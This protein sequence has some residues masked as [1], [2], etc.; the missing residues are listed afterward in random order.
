MSHSFDQQTQ[1]AENSQRTWQQGSSGSQNSFDWQRSAEQYDSRSGDMGCSNA[2]SQTLGSNC[3][4]RPT[5]NEGPVSESPGSGA[6]PGERQDLCQQTHNSAEN[7][8]SNPGNGGGNKSSRKRGRRGNKDNPPKE[9]PAP[10]PLKKYK[11]SESDGFWS[12]RNDFWKTRGDLRV[13]FKTPP[14]AAAGRPPVHWSIEDEAEDADERPSHL[15]IPVE[16][17]NNLS[18]S[19]QDKTERSDA[20]SKEGEVSPAEENKEETDD[21]DLA[22]YTTLKN[23]IFLQIEENDQDMLSNLF[24]TSSDLIAQAACRILDDA[25]LTLLTLLLRYQALGMEDIQV[26]VQ[27]AFQSMTRG[28]T[29]EILQ[30]AEMLKGLVLRFFRC[31]GDKNWNALERALGS[32]RLEFIPLKKFLMTEIAKLEGELQKAEEISEKVVQILLLVGANNNYLVQ[33]SCSILF[34]NQEKNSHNVQSVS[35]LE[36]EGYLRGLLHSSF[37]KAFQRSELPL[38]TALNLI[39]NFFLSPSHKSGQQPGGLEADER[40]Q[41]DT[42]Y[43]SLIQGVIDQYPKKKPHEGCRSFI[44]VLLAC[45][46]S[47]NVLMLMMD[48]LTESKLAEH[49]AN[50]KMIEMKDVQRKRSQDFKRKLIDITDKEFLKSGPKD[51]PKEL[52]IRITTKFYIIKNLPTFNQLLDNKESTKKSAST[53]PGYLSTIA[54]LSNYEPLV[55]YLT[56]KLIAGRVPLFTVGVFGNI[57]RRTYSKEMTVARGACSV[58]IKCQRRLTGLLKDSRKS[59]E[60]LREVEQFI[61]NSFKNTYFGQNRKVLNLAKRVKNLIIQFF[62]ENFSKSEEEIN[63]QVWGHKPSVKSTRVFSRSMEG[64]KEFMIFTGTKAD[65]KSKSDV[66]KCIQVL[67]EAGMDIESLVNFCQ[68]RDDP[69][70]TVL[71]NNYLWKCGIGTVEERCPVRTELKMLLLEPFKKVGP[72]NLA[73]PV[74]ITDLANFSKTMCEQDKSPPKINKQI[75]KQEADEGELEDLKKFLIQGVID[76]YPKLSPKDGCESFIKVLSKCQL[77]HNVLMETMDRFTESKLNLHFSNPNILE[78]KDVHGKRSLAYRK[79]LIKKLGPVFN[80][81][82][83]KDIP[84][85]LLV[86]ITTKFYVMKNLPTF[87]K[88]LEGKPKT[89]DSVFMTPAETLPNYEPLVQHLT[90]K[91]TTAQIPLLTVGVF[92]SIGKKVFPKATMVARGACS[93]L[94]KGQKRFSVLLNDCRNG[95]EGLAEVEKF[96]ENSFRNTYFGQGK[97]VLNQA[98]TVKTMILQFFQENSVKTAEEINVQIWGQKLQEKNAKIFSR[99]LDGLKEFLICRASKTEPK[100]KSCAPQSVQVIVESGMD[101]ESLIRFCQ[102]KEDPSMKNLLENNFLWK[103]GIEE[104]CPVRK[105]LKELL[106]EPFKRVGPDYVPYPI[107]IGGLASF[108]KLMRQ[109]EDMKEGESNPIKSEEGDTP[110]VKK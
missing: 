83:P 49:F 94:I 50:P 38:Q 28:Q 1:V 48:N 39:T 101:I 54:I 63:V 51:I 17:T 72:D 15:S 32:D 61:E 62:R 53:E 18:N 16:S 96:V 47:H 23:F 82:G 89:S 2:H 71:D 75:E 103:Y 7:N 22:E 36:F 70:L 10:N 79:W 84:L 37:E 42:L 24:G 43:K 6:H 88:L 80:K 104:K 108:C 99:S 91:L 55:Q 86:G 68:E 98:D 11:S 85:K 9:A 56:A 4:P 27:E 58:L 73:Y 35:R 95:K 29:G 26:S 90:T 8:I 52:L 12:E 69:S 66:S 77:S 21:I 87:E 105:G 20:S 92:G 34:A 57:G 97:D 31:H 5:W 19:S 109:Q 110:T 100:F 107:F 25:S 65:P 40:E 102:E 14:S 81:L 59:K 41:F 45:R 3:M 93:V 76:Y 78:L 44:T 30:Q 13:P 67:I 33:K 60:G 64:L 74:F 106:L 46:L